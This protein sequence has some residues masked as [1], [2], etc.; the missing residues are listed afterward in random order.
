MVEIMIIIAITREMDRMCYSCRES[1]RT[2]TII[3]T[4]I[5]VMVT[6]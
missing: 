4:I 5:V 3:I 1:T 2:I 6:F